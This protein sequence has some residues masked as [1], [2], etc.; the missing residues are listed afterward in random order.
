M[1]IEKNRVLR[2]LYQGLDGPQRFAQDV[3]R[4]AGQNNVYLV[5]P[6][7]QIWQT[8]TSLAPA[9]SIEIVRRIELPK[10]PEITEPRGG[11]PGGRGGRGGGGGGGGGR[12][13]PGGGGPGGGPGGGG[14]PIGGLVAGETEFVIAIWTIPTPPS[15]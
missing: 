14:G 11:G 15:R 13:G 4:W 10:A 1:Q 8:A 12:R 7:N 6:E 2:S 3:R 9:S 5:G